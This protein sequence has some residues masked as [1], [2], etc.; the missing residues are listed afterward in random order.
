MYFIHLLTQFKEGL[1]TAC[2]ED[3]ALELAGLALQATRG[4]YDPNDP[5]CDYTFEL[6]EVLPPKHIDKSSAGTQQDNDN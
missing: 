1:F 5:A 4:D 3:T 2:D 6:A